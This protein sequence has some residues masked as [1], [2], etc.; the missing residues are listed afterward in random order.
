[1]PPRT[2]VRGIA[3][4]RRSSPSHGILAA[5]A[6]H[7]FEQRRA[8]EID[9]AEAAAIDQ[10]RDRQ[11]HAGLHAHAPE[12][13]LA[14]AHG[15]VE[16]LDV[17][18]STISL[19]GRSCGRKTA[20]S[21]RVSSRVARKFGRAVTARASSM[22]V[23]SRSPSLRSGPPPRGGEEAQALASAIWRSRLQ[24][25]AEGRRSSCQASGR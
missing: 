15:F 13:L 7:H 17:G 8:R 3:A 14:V 11:R 4:T 5:G 24:L 20:S 12:A 19:A 18:H 9:D 10:R 1:M 2:R 23:E 22:W 6:D 16:K 21:Q 25:A